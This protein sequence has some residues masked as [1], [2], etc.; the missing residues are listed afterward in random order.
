VTRILLPRSTAERLAATMSRRR[1]LALTGAAL[2][3]AACGSDDKK[4]DRGLNMYTF[5]EY[6]DPELLAEWGDVSLSIYDSTEDAIA[7]LA[8][9]GDSSGYDI[10]VPTGI[11]I[12]QMVASGM[13][14][15]LDLDRIPNFVNL[16]PAYVNQSWDPGNQ[17]SV[18][19]AWGTTGWLYDTSVV[20]TEI[21][22]WSD[23]LTAAQTEASGA[24]SVLD[25]P[26]NIVGLYFWA[27]GIDWNTEDAAELDAC[28]EFLVNELAPHI[29]AFD[30]YPGLTLIGGSYALAHI[31]NGDARAALLAVAEGG[32]DPEQ[33]RWG[34]GAPETELWMDNWCIVD[35]AANEDAA[36]DFINFVLDPANS[37]RELQ[38]HGFHTGLKGI[39][40]AVGDIE[41][42]DMV[43][44]T[45]DQVATMRAGDVNSA[46]DRRVDILSK[47][48]AAAGA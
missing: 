1:F 30:S 25:S 48:K 45:P 4:V 19:K 33:Y 3:V 41:L 22:T 15:E 35:G 27:N 42:K 8:Q 28:E 10:V 12:P 11:Y 31:W 2:A 21:A 6:D 43:F 14:A 7:K 39:E 18:C 47:V 44:F 36:Y 17:Y 34:I 16:D 13:L 9:T 29:K 20:T 23:F 40:E 37:A 32:G 38:Y 26:P 5:A 46:Q 24:T